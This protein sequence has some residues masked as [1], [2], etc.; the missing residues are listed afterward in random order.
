MPLADLV[1]MAVDHGFAVV[2]VHEATLDEWD[3][4]ESGFSAGCATWLAEHGADHPDAAEVPARAAGQRA[5]TSVATGG[6]WDWPTSSCSLSE[7]G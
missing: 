2:G 7:A 5:A 3:E 4:F 1:D 6:P